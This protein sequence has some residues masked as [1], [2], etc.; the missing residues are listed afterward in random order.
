M[1]WGGDVG[2]VGMT[3]GRGVG[4]GR[5][6]SLETMLEELMVEARAQVAEHR[7][8]DAWELAAFDVLEELAG[9]GDVVGLARLVGLMRER[10][11]AE[12]A[13]HE[14][15]ARLSAACGVVGVEVAS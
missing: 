1:V 9:A 8:S 3:A 15:M 7:R 14:E 4:R 6:V 13:R 10:D 12:N 2:G 11:R 5:P